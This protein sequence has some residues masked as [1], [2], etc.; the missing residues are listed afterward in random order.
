M[1]IWKR[2][3]VVTCCCCRAHREWLKRW[4]LQQKGEGQGGGQIE[5]EG[6]LHTMRASGAY[7][8]SIA[9]HDLAASAACVLSPAAAADVMRV[10]CSAMRMLRSLQ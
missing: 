2:F 8:S 3:S 10:R 1:V 4:Y 5:S 7:S 6:W 9:S